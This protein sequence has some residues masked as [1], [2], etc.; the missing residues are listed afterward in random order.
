MKINTIKYSLID[1][2]KSLKRNTTLSFASIITVSLT[3]L[4]FGIFLLSMLNANE[5]MKSIESKLEVSVFIKDEAKIEERQNIQ[6][7]L[8]GIDGVVGIKYVTKEQAL[9]KWKE[10]LGKDNEDLVQGFD[11]KNPLP[12]SY[13]VKVRGSEVIQTVVDGTKAMPGIERVVANEDLV[14]RISSITKGIKWT[15]LGA[16]LILIPVCLLLIGNTIKLAVYSRR[17]EVN[18]MKY[19]GATDWFIRWPFIMEGIIIGL[20][21]SIFSGIVLGYVYKFVYSKLSS[22]IVMIKLITPSY[23][24]TNVLWMF[25]LSGILIGALGSI[26]SIRKFLKV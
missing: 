4:M 14:N 17:K 19:V 12:E 5:V 13:T 16:L 11:E 24:V 25:V 21:G 26:I 22:T 7:A 6:N 2:L 3:L 10:Q 1:A 9:Q 15:G 18:I 23:F 8:K 20:V